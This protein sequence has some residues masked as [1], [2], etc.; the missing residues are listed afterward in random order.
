MPELLTNKN[1][2]MNVEQ[3]GKWQQLLWS[4]TQLGEKVISSIVTKSRKDV[5]RFNIHYGSGKDGHSVKLETGS[6]QERN[7]WVLAVQQMVVY[8][9]RIGFLQEKY[10]NPNKYKNPT[11][12]PQDAEVAG[13]Q[14]TSES[15]KKN[16]GILRSLMTTK[17]QGPAV[18]GTAQ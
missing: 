12:S 11:N 7:N 9:L 8:H 4:D 1:E 3:W 18:A 15:G 17:S 16:K 6:E 5:R 13:L 10:S 14:V 2:E